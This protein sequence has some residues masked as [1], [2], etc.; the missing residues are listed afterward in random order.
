MR[1]TDFIEAMNQA[2]VNASIPTSGTEQPEATDTHHR[3]DESRDLLPYSAVNLSR[4]MLDDVELQRLFT[5]TAKNY[6][7]ACLPPFG[8]A[9]NR[10]SLASRSFTAGGDIPAGSLVRLSG[11]GDPSNN[12]LYRVVSVED[13][14]TR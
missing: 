9:Q 10:S 13:H 7:R 2:L 11:F 12:G 4:D 1:D 3:S 6:Q 8:P 5:A 14:P